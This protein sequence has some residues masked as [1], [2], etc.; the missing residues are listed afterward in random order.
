MEN[1]RDRPRAPVL[2]FGCPAMMMRSAPLYFDNAATSFP[3]P[4]AVWDAMDR[5]NRELGANAGRSAYPEAQMSAALVHECR[6][7]L[8]ELFGVRQPDRF[9]FG[10]NATDCLNLAIKGSVRRGDHVIATAME[11]NS[12]LRPLNELEARGVIEYTRVPCS[13]TGQVEPGWIEREIRSHTRLIIMVHGSNVT[14]S[15]LPLA[16]VGSVAKDN[17][18]RF[19]VDASQTAGSYPLDFS[20]LPVDLVAFSGHK[21]LLGP[22]GTGVLYVAG[23]V[24]LATLRE[25]GT[26]SLSAEDLQP[27]RLP[28]RF[29]PGT[30]NVPGLVGLTEGVKF[31][32][33][34]CVADVRAHKQRLVGAF[35]EGLKSTPAVVTYGPKTNT[36]NVGVV[37]LSI[38][39]R[40]PEE[41]ARRLAERYHLSVRAGLHCAPWAHRT[42]GT[43]PQGTVRFSFGCFNTLEEVEAAVRAVHELSL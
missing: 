10:L 21:G 43:F 31:L 34:K 25:G 33:A 3:K 11:H 32:L 37:S 4:S 26:G 23:E 1:P 27:D 22:M 35:L 15:I 40:S 16:E 19:L 41:V 7:R 9:V 38:R 14:G 6:E 20:R 29:E 36:D 24:E 5:F 18:I 13:P 39:G 17:G 12:V 30:P 8:A 42:L 2:R 28:D